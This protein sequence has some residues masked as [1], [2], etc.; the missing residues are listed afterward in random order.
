MRFLHIFT[1]PADLDTEALRSLELLDSITA[2]H[3]DLCTRPLLLLRATNTGAALEA[4]DHFEHV[5]ACF[6]TPNILAVA[7]SGTLEETIT[8][9][10]LKAVHLGGL[11][12]IK[13]AGTGATLWSPVTTG[14]GRSD[15]LS[16]TARIV[17]L[18]Q[19]GGQREFT[20]IFQG[21]HKAGLFL[22]Q[23]TVERSMRVDG[24]VVGACRLLCVPASSISNLLAMGSLTVDTHNDGA[25]TI[26][27]QG[28]TDRCVWG[29]GD[30]RGGPSDWAKI[31]GGEVLSGN[32]RKRDEEE[33]ALPLP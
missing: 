13:N 10:K 16:D 9:I 15:F 23:Y 14:S 28:V 30:D 7:P 11:I 31:A 17:G 2:F 21:L 29:N 27:F 4:L 8:T 24:S 33:T 19:H 18:P 22:G 20:S 6:A 1:I 3:S 5:A 12:S 25:V 32:I 26:S